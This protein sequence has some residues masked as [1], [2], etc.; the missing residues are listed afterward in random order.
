MESGKS[1]FHFENPK[2]KKLRQSNQGTLMAELIQEFM[3]WYRLDYSL[4]VFKPEVNLGQG[5]ANKAELA[6]KAGLSDNQTEPL[7]LQLLNAFN[8]GAVGT[9]QRA[10]EPASMQTSAAKK[11]EPLSFSEMPPSKATAGASKNTNDSIN[12]HLAKAN[13]LLAEID[14]EDGF[15]LRDSHDNDFDLDGLPSA[16]KED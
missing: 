1:S 13:N 10:P 15:N 3:E 12:Q 9:G 11:I 7:L 16:S 8:S 4:A 6:S 14:K 5:K 2:A